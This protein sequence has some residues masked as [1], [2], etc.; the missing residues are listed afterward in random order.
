MD[1]R[2]IEEEVISLV[3][4]IAE[5]NSCLKMEDVIEQS[6]ITSMNF[7]MLVMKIEKKYQIEF[8]DDDVNFK[9]LHTIENLVDYVCERIKGN[10]KT[11]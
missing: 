3:Q 11:A 7:I 10:E 6:G 8:D 1:R 5:N 4:K 2:K 9:K